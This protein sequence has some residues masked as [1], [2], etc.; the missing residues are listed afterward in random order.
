[1]RIKTPLERLVELKKY[2][3][4]LGYSSIEDLITKAKA[5]KRSKEVYEKQAH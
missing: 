2:L 3:P 5:T 4:H 1:M